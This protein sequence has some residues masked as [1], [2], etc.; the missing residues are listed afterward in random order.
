MKLPKCVFQKYASTLDV[1]MVTEGGRRRLKN[2]FLFFKL[3]H[4]N[5]QKVV[6]L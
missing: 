3:V 5:W 6:N 1:A 4:L 2:I